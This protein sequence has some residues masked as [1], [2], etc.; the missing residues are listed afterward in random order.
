MGRCSI[1]RSWSFLFCFCGWTLCRCFVVLRQPWHFHCIWFQ[2]PTRKDSVLSN[3]PYF[4][5]VFYT[6]CISLLTLPRCPQYFIF[7]LMSGFFKFCSWL[8]AEHIYV[9]VVWALT[10]IIADFDFAKCA[11]D[12]KSY[13]MHRKGATALWILLG[14]P[15]L[16]SVTGFQV[17]LE[18]ASY[19][20]NVLLIALILFVESVENGA[21]QYAGYCQWTWCWTTGMWL[22]RVILRIAC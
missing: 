12:L 10:A 7:A 18:M 4:V 21:A 5:R 15:G 16:T 22:D 11:Y 8:S 19:S 9:Q 17:L 2:F 1:G 3:W 6:I 13:T 20:T 14:T